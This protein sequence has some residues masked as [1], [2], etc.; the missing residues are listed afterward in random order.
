[1]YFNESLSLC[2]SPLFHVIFV[3][4]KLPLFCTCFAFSS[5]VLVENTTFKVLWFSETYVI[6]LDS[7]RLYF[8]LYYPT[9][10]RTYNPSD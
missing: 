1:M 4:V 6:L 5:L 3:P 2:F 10:T 9:V 7:L 8:N